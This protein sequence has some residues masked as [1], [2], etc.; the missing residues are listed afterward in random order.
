MSLA[1]EILAVARQ[2][3]ISDAQ[4][5]HA[6][7]LTLTAFTF[8]LLFVS[9]SPHKCHNQPFQLGIFTPHITPDSHTKNE[10]IIHYNI[11]EKYFV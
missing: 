7:M 1:R 3:M 6:K 11:S 2:C 4:S 5:I 9:F 10:E 8:L